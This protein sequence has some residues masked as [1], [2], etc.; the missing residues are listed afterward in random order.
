MRVSPVNLKILAYTLDVEGFDSARALR[1]CGITSFD[2]LQEDG[3]WVP[4]AQFDRLMA[5]AIEVTG[6]SAFGLVAGKSL[7]LMKYGAITPV[8]LS[9]PSLRQ[10]L[11][12]IHRFA[13]LTVARSE[14]ELVESAAGARLLI[15]PV[16][17]AGLS[18]H[19]RTEQVATSAVN[20]L[21]YAGAGNADIRHVDFPYAPPAFRA[22]RVRDPLQPGLAGHQAAHARP[23]GLYG[24]LHASRVPARGHAVGL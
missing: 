11:A 2:A 24:G 15:Q 7:A 21:R 12:D 13:P 1:Q 4:V 9:T 20:M 17:S 8:V 19:F 23:G 18:G 14:V 16:T 3:D 5:A 10:M 22:Q 6:D